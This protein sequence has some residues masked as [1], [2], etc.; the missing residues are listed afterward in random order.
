MTLSFLEL[1]DFDLP[2][3]SEELVTE[4]GPCHCVTKKAMRNDVFE[5]Y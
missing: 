2:F 1:D 3:S 4:T 5:A